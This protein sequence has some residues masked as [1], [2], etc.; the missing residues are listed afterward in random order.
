MLKDDATSNDIVPAPSPPEI[1]NSSVGAK[2]TPDRPAYRNIGEPIG[3]LRSRSPW[4][5][6]PA[7][8]AL[9][10]G[11][12]GIR[13]SVEFFGQGISPFALFFPVVLV[14]T[15]FGGVGPGLM[16]LTIASV[17]A[18]YLW[19]EPQ[20]LLALSGPEVISFTLFVTSNLVNIFVVDRLRKSL[21]SLRESEAQLSLS[22]EVG[23][24]G[25]WDLD[26][27]TGAVWRSP[28][29][30]EVT[31]IDPDHSTSVADFIARVDDRDR[32]RVTHA[33]ERAL[34][35]IELLDIEFRFIRDSG[36][37]LWLVGRADLFRDAQG[38]PARLV[39]IIFDTT[40]IRT[41]EIERDQSNSLLQT[42]FETLPGAAFA[43][44]LEGRYILAN[45]IVAAAIGHTPD[46]FLG[47]HDMELLI[48]KD[49]ARTIMA[50]D[51]AVIE[52]GKP[53]ELEEELLLPNGEMSHWL[54]MKA[55]F[56]DAAGEPQ[57]IVCI[58]LDVTDRRKSEER[59]RFLAD[60]VDHRAKNLLGVVLSLVRL[61]KVG[62]VAAFKAAV[63]GR[64]EAL[65]R[66]HTLLA[67]NRWQGVNIAVLVH[68]EL[69][70]FRRAGAERIC[71]S[72][73]ALM[74]EPN[75]AQALA[76]AVH[77]LAINAGMYG[78]LSV[79]EGQLAVAWELS[80]RG[81]DT[82]LELY[83]T[84]S[85]G[86]E[87]SQ[88]AEP[89][90]GSTAIRGAIEHQLGGEF[91]LTWE[92]KGITCRIAFPV[93]RNMA[94]APSAAAP[95]QEDTSLAPSTAA[96][97]DLAGKRVL[98]LEDE[99]LI[100]M[101]LMDILL[102][103]GCTIVGAASS[104]PAALDRLELV[105]PDLAILDVN[106]A[107]SSSAPVAKALR[108]RGVPFIYCTGYA[109]PALQIEQDLIAPVLTK[110]VDPRELAEA[111]RKAISD[112][113]VSCEA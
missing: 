109:E 63:S 61:T 106:L 94:P 30:Y 86:P 23:K 64:I 65:A 4:I 110:P 27:K 88:P 74:L 40:P 16:S 47:R 99:A 101:T 41:A 108:A 44:D 95:R 5:T 71:L 82:I 49:Q 32:D 73:P 75:A 91:D 31:G 12:A 19:L 98:V 113:R 28:S 62:D 25:M 68:E 26:P 90:F 50:N 93:A 37:T 60:E 103:L 66:A 92:P 80:E 48:D 55:P 107:G 33:Y 13:S 96:A 2:T 85:G 15:L 45:P 102:E 39:G 56:L 1:S 53:L 58:S 7:A 51:R 29:F 97:I 20:G 83:W 70:P 59:L 3:F 81:A 69:E 34:Q 112:L 104:A 57:G 76:M 52:A 21:A 17:A 22:Q 38:R 78:A 14:C 89:G 84:E 9:T 24:I 54:S 10:A 42:F 87:V 79:E 6:Y 36:E 35:G 11:V 111:L 105:T 43:K 46:T 77:E 18:L 100:A 8:I 72:G 67:A